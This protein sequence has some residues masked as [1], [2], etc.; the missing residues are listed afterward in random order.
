MG[1]SNGEGLSQLYLEFVD[2]YRKWFMPQ[3]ENHRIENDI[4][5]ITHGPGNPLLDN[6]EPIWTD[7]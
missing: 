6:I 1:S 5:E 7:A 4:P 3:N 2:T